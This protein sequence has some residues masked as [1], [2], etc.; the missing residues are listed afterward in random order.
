MFKLQTEMEAIAVTEP[1]M[2]FVMNPET[3]EEDEHLVP[4]ARRHEGRPELHRPE[5]LARA[6]LGADDSDRLLGAAPE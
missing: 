1:R 5:L 2:G 3:L 6:R 4:A